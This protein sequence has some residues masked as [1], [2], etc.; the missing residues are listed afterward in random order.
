MKYIRLSREV[1]FILGAN[2]VSW[3]CPRNKNLWVFGGN[4]GKRYADNSR[5][6]FI[7]CSRNTKKECIWL[8]QDPNILNQV[9]KAGYRA[10]K[11]NSIQGLYYGFRASWH[12]YD[13]SQRDTSIYS[14]IGARHLNLWHG[15]PIKNLEGLYSPSLLKKVF[16]YFKAIILRAGLKNSRHFMVYPNTSFLQHYERAFGILEKNI[17]ISNQPR[18]IVFSDTIAQ[19]DVYRTDGEKK[20]LLQLQLLKKNSGKIIGYFP[21]WRSGGAENFM[22]IQDF[23]DL[24][25][26]NDLLKANNSYIVAKR[27][28]CSFSQY[29]HPGYSKLAEENQNRIAGLSNFIALDFSIDLNAVVTE[30]DVLISDYSGA[31]IDYL[32]TQKPMIMYCYDLA[33]YQRS[34]GLYFDFNEY[35]FGHLVQSVGDLNRCLEDYFSD[36]D[37]FSKEYEADRISLRRKFFDNESCFLPIV[38]TLLKN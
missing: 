28:T 26:L 27:H 37:R 15:I 8:T 24:L 1:L 4:L 30:C 10:Y 17:T 16:G 33:E 23:S 3:L 13:V 5:Y 32:L 35:R 19:T 38:E 18:N 21:T 22:G 29:N 6:F 34:P 31:M 9:I 36:K 12:I 11:A 7:Y 2:L 14:S 25:A 20:V